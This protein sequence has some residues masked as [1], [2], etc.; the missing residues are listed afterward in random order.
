MIKHLVLAATFVSL[1]ICFAQPARADSSWIFRR[2]YYSHDP[3]TPVQIGNL[4]PY[5]V[6]PVRA[7]GTYVRFGYRRLHSTIRVGPWSHDHLNVY[8][9]WVQTGGY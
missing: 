6:R 7:P 2:S 3:I 4:S 5:P 1:G 8:E 9:S